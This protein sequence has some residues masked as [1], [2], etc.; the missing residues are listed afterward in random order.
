[1]GRAVYQNKTAKIGLCNVKPFFRQAT[2]NIEDA[3][4]SRN[5][6]SPLSGDCH[7]WSAVGVSPL[8]YSQVVTDLTFTPSFRQPTYLPT[9]FTTFTDSPV[10]HILSTTKY[11]T[12]LTS[13][14]K[15]TS[16]PAT[17]Q[18]VI[19]TAIMA[20]LSRFAPRR[21][22]SRLRFRDKKSSA[23]EIRDEIRDEMQD[24]SPTVAKKK[25]TCKDC[26][27]TS[28]SHRLVLCPLS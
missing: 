27:P 8:V 23:T 21:V 5:W 2:H 11:L 25:S 28:A 7:L 19:Q 6:L 20:P 15:H 24:A 14:F 16:F 13:A 4:L 9:P 1:M 26:I 22:L 3:F 10:H 12:F 17:I 18:T